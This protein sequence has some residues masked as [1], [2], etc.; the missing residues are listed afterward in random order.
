MKTKNMIGLKVITLDAQNLGEIDGVHAD[1]NTWKIT[2]LDVKL[3]REAIKEMGLKKPK[4][5][6]LIVCIPI[7]YVKRF[8]DVITLNHTQEDIKNLKEST[9][10]QNNKTS[11][12]S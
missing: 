2:D 6:S 4:L 7:T 12:D 9:T 8:G 10:A 3:N 11:S 5:G 1:I